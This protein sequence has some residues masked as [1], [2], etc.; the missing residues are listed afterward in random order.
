MD[1]QTKRRDTDMHSGYAA[2]YAS[3]T[4]EEDEDTDVVEA[5]VKGAQVD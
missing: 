3:C 4:V 2:C 5:D 1:V